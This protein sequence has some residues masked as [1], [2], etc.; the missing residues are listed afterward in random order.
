MAQ[1]NNRYGHTKYFSK[2]RKIAEG[3]NGCSA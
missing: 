3:L 1:R 2:I